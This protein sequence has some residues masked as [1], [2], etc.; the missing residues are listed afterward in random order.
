MLLFTSA[1]PR[2]KALLQQIGFCEGIDF[3]LFDIKGNFKFNLFNKR[4]KIDEVKKLVIEAAQL[5]IQ[6][7]LDD[8]EFYQNLDI[9]GRKKTV[10]IGIDTIVYFKQ[11]VLDRPLLI[12]PQGI[13]KEIRNRANEKV[14]KML[15]QLKGEDFSVLTGLVLAQGDNPKNKKTY[16]VATEAKMKQYSD[17]DIERYTQTGEPLDKAGGFGIQERGVILFEKIKGSYSNVVGLPIYEFVELLQD[18]LFEGR[19]TWRIAEK[20]YS[21]NLPVTEGTPELSVVSVGDINYDI[22]YS[23]LPEQF[24]STLK[25]PGQHVRG[26][27]KCSPGGTAVIFA[28]K[29]KEEGFKKC[30]V[31]GVIG[32]DPLGKSIEE[33]LNRQC[34]NTILPA[35]YERSTSVSLILRDTREKDTSI[36]ITDSC[37]ALSVDDVE[38]ASND[39]RK[40][41]VVFVSGY[42]LT[43]QNR[44][45]AACKVMELAK[46]NGQ[47]LVLDVHVDMNK[48]IDYKRFLD[49]TKGKVDIL[50]A[51]ISTILAWLGE[52]EHKQDDWDFLI[53][54]IIP[55]LKEIP[56]LLLR[57]SSYSHEIIVSPSG[58]LGPNELDYF[59][60]SSEQRLG[61]AD[62]RTACILYQ[63]MSPRILLASASPRRLELLR[64]IITKNQIEI[65]SSNHPEEIKEGETPEE[66]VR[67]L[68]K[69]KAQ[70]VFQNDKQYSPNIRVI[71]GADTEI[72]LDGEVQSKPKDNDEARKILK[73]LSGRE[74]QAITGLAL[75]D[76]RTGEIKFNDIVSTK[77]EFKTLTDDEIEHYIQSCEPIGK[78]GAYGI[79]GKAACFIKQIE[80][81]Y[82]NVVGLPLEYLSTILES[83]FK[84]SIWNLNKVSNWEFY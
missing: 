62:K 9:L 25:P 43:D 8:D 42:C 38:K 2:R 5:K 49:L 54:D 31:L 23:R 67:R 16:C 81:S 66:R 20:N 64:Q 75:M 52:N 11:R 76:A 1:S 69:E 3:K 19:V 40:A 15:S 26:E 77:V 63:L 37:Q 59:Q 83:E 39:I 35:N 57:T 65:L 48:R 27:I 78:A 73:K 44:Q 60:V 79:Q 55:K 82:T 14:R 10:L 51:E 6:K 24:F 32:G 70:Q 80:G 17:N 72:V 7:A 61:Y 4:L 47:L 12:N 18:P 41:D 45:E 50:S 58:I 29:A 22:S 68:A 74:H 34:I 28:L 46:E 33:D 30:S 53:R 56:T 84:I 71:I 36:T 13:D 21:E